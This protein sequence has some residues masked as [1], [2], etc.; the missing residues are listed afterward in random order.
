LKDR[1]LNNY[2]DL[3]KEQYIVYGTDNDGQILYDFFSYS[4]SVNAIKN[5]VVNSYIVHSLHQGAIEKNELIKKVHDFSDG[6]LS[7]A[8][9]HRILNNLSSKGRI[10]Y[11]FPNENMVSLSSLEEE[12]I[13]RLIDDYN[14][15]LSLFHA[16]I[17]QIITKFS[18]YI[19]K[20]E[21]IKEIGGLI[22]TNF[23]F[24]VLEASGEMSD[25][26]TVDSLQDLLSFIK[27]G[28]VDEKIAEQILTEIIQLCKSNDIVFR[29]SAGKVFSKISNPDSFGNYV[30]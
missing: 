27:R 29:I 8:A 3:A 24:E 20:D 26:A 12:R 22:E 15:K 14:E 5:Q 30:R 18:L 6:T 17:Q 28:N 23:N 7:D 2:P 11:N 9:V 1:L 10:K 19:S 21:L 4:T 25:Y 13:A 16:G